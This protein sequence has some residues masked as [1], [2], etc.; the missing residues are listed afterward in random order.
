[1]DLNL[2]APIMKKSTLSIVSFAINFLFFIQMGGTLVSSIYTLDLLNTSLD[3]K[4]LGVLFFFFPAIFY[5]FKKKIPEWLCWMFLAGLIL[6]RGMLPTLNTNG[7]MLVS[8]IGTA[9][10]LGLFPFLLN[11]RE[12][13]GKSGSQGFSASL[14]L[15]LTLIISIMLRSLNSGIDYSLTMKGSWVGWVMG[16]IL[17]ISL[18]SLERTRIGIEQSPESDNGKIPPV[19]SSLFGIFMILSLIYFIFSA[20]GVLARW[21]EGNYKAIVILV[22]IF[23]VGWFI[24]RMLFRSIYERISRRFIIG[25]NILFSVSL[26]AMIFVNQIGF[27]ET[28]GSLPVTV[29]APSIWML[30][31]LYVMI[32]LFPIIFVDME[33]LWNRLSGSSLSPRQLAPGMMLGTFTLV[34]LVFMNIFSNV[35][36]YVEPVSPFFRNKFYLPFLIITFILC[37]IVL[38][39]KESFSEQKGSQKRSFPTIWNLLFLIFILFTVGGLAGKPN[40]P[41][42]V[43]IARSLKVMTYNIQQGNDNTGEQSYLRQLAIIQQ[44]TPDILVL[45][46]SD[47]TRI[48][49]N[50]IDLVRFFADNLGYYSYYGPKTISGSYGTAILSRY[51]LINT[52]TIFTFSDQDENGTAYAQV[53]VGNKTFNIYNVHPDG[54]DDAKEAFAKMLLERTAGQK[55]VIIMGDFNLRQ[56]EAA[57]KMIDSVFINSWIHVYPTGISTDGVDM[58]GRN[59]I[60][61]IF[62]SSDLSVRNPVYVLPPDS[63]TDHPV[64]WAE[65]YWQN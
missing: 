62:I 46:E 10:S 17:G 18:I 38:L 9:L 35:W 51:P 5:I 7:R 13:E 21:T 24:S 37:L 43:S 6:S 64:H 12:I 53:E 48:S 63:A 32:I 50:N 56:N 61:H 42:N 1:M 26:L 15:A 29:G 60:D 59:R 65:I 27:P 57:Y 40:Q 16:L 2:E 34:V 54:S 28:V 23:S 4:A 14:G 47:S 8:G 25:W 58:S 19:T 20:P 52:Q 45:Q 44:V 36:G 33:Y 31:P 22:D 30:V 41:E 3:A 39:G 49:I 55:N 11:T